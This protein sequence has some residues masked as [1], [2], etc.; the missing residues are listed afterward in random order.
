MCKKKELGIPQKKSVRLHNQ[1]N[2]Q[3]LGKS[4]KNWVK[5]SFH[6]QESHF[7]SQ[8]GLACPSVNR[9]ENPLKR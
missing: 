9:A 4:K 8:W 3:S 5:I 1:E 2:D 7:T 6:G